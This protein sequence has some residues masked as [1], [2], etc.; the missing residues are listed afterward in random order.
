VN[1]V[2]A[3]LPELE[4]SRTRMAGRPWPTLH[5]QVGGRMQLDGR[6]IL[7]FGSNDYLGLGAHPAGVAGAHAAL[8][9]FGAGSGMNPVLAVTT[10]H[11]ELMEAMREFTGCEDVLLF[12]SCTAANCALISTLVQEGD[13]VIS[14]ELNHASI[15]DGCRLS[16]GRTQV[17]RHA[18]VPSL[19]EELG[20]SQ[21]A[22]LRLVITDGVFSME[23]EA[24]PLAGI[25]AEARAARAVVAIDESHAAGVIGPTGRGTFELFGLTDP[26]PVQTGTF[27]KAFGAGIGGYVAGPR[28][29]ID[30]LRDQ[31]RFFIFTSGMPAAAAGAAL[32]SLRIMR[33]EPERLERLRANIE[34]FRA[35]MAALGY[36]LLGGAGP[37]VPVLV[38][39]S[40]RARR[41]AAHLLNRGVYVPAMAYPIVPQGEARLRVQL[42]AA[43]SEEDVAAVVDAFES[44]LAAEGSSRGAAPPVR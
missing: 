18:G 33:G 10:V 41:L 31:A 26:P 2:L 3:E 43:H 8:D 6:E 4:A 35:G 16:R 44:A 20:A 13:A 28:G 9:K 7:M 25:V 36:S 27:S 42:S 11:R 38:H 12:N 37:I 15:I 30:F 1:E 14:D 22:R 40:D 19:R 17:Y 32:A 23:G 21:T 29:L 39:D 34:H 5:S 24:A